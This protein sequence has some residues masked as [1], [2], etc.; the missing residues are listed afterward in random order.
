PDLSSIEPVIKLFREAGFTTKHLL[1]VDWRVDG[2]NQS[3]IYKNKIIKLKDIA[4]T[5]GFTEWYVYSKDEQTYEE[6][7]KHKRALEIVHE[8]G[9]KNFVACERDTALLMRGLLDVTILPRTTPLA[10]FHQQGGTLVVNGDMSLELWE[11][12]NKWK[13]SD[14]T[15]LFIT[16]GVIKKLKGAYVYFAQNLPVQPNRNYKLEYEVVNMATPGLS[17]SQGGGSCVSK[18]IMLP[19]NTGHHA[20]I[21]RTNNLRS[22]RFAAEVDSEFILDNI[23]VSAVTSEN[24]K[25]IIPWAYNNP[26]AGIEKP[27]TYKMIYGKSLIID[28]FKG[29]CN[30]AYQSG[31]C[32][33]DWANETWRPH[34][35]AYPTQ[36][37]PIPTLQWEALR[38]GI[39]ALRYSIVE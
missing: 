16:D 10:N 18:S 3:D 25:E 30:Y 5:Y 29:V 22:L 32:W 2:W 38:E 8:L 9:G 36:E 37:T 13:S 24:G 28:G 23:S 14:E 26:Q 20:V 4:L 12:G 6:L 17:L 7:I 34:V 1:Y 27:G 33:N 39:D 35:M 19:S 15:H 31:E 21:F 11:N